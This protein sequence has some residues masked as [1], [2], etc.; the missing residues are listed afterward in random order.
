MPVFDFSESEYISKNVMDFTSQSA[1]FSNA[2][3]FSELNQ[4]SAGENKYI[5]D[6]GDVIFVCVHALCSSQH[7]FQSYRD[8]S[9]VKPGLAEGHYLFI[10]SFIYLY[11]FYRG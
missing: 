4:F 1:F 5:G 6:Q 10:Y 8:A 3:T 2:R 9:R 7:F 11:N